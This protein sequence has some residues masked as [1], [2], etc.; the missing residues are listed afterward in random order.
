[1]ILKC[2]TICKTAMKRLSAKE[3]VIL[4]E[5]AD[6]PNGSYGLEIVKRSKGQIKRGTVYVYLNR[7]GEHG[8]VQANK[9][10]PMKGQGGLPR[11]SYAI[12]ARG[13]KVL[14]AEESCHLNV[15]ELHA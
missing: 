13:Q 5:L 11:P 14:Q 1:M 8:L 4:R 7:L 10:E 6:S 12:T 15:A 3:I 9:A 2:L